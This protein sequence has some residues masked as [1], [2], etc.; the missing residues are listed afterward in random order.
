[1]LRIIKW[2]GIVLGGIIGLIVL[3]VVAVYVITEMRINKSYTVEPEAITI[4]TDEAAIEHGKHLVTAIGKCGDCHGA[5]LAGQV[6]IDAPPGK[7]F[8]AN[9]TAGQGGVGGTY[10]DTDWVRSIRHGVG[11]DGKP[12]LF[13]PAQEFYYFSDADLGDL[14]AYLKSVPPVDNEP[15]ASEVRPLG[16]V[17]FITGQLPLIPAELID[18]AAP[19]LVEAEPGVTVEYGKYLT[20]VGCIGCHGPGLSGGQVPG[21]PPGAPEFP[22][23]TNLTPGGATDGWSEADFINAMR[24]GQRPN[25]TQLH[26]FMPWP[27]VGQMT[28]DE[29][30]ATWAYLQS[31]PA[32]PDGNR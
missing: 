18:H 1:M 14:I 16:R 26:L 15:V 29:L 6:F 9:L 17:L 3:A 4:P 24:T 13:M 12:L 19:H 28:D 11:P 7:L 5:N 22:P 25:G 32:K 27:A 10:G 20:I 8:A 21:T 2:I 30:K 23:A 31:V